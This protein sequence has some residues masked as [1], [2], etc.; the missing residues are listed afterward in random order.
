MV[1]IPSYTHERAGLLRETPDVPAAPGGTTVPAF[2]GGAA[3]RL[4]NWPH[5]TRAEAATV[6]RFTDRNGRCCAEPTL[7]MEREVLGVDY[8]STCST[9]RG[10]GRRA[11]RPP[12]APARRHRRQCRL[13][14][15]C[16]L[17]P[18]PGVASSA[19]TC[20]SSGRG[21]PVNG[22]AATVSPPGRRSWSPPGPVVHTDVMC[23]LG[24]KLSVLRA[25]RQLLRPGG[26]LAF[27]TIHAALAKAQGP[28]RR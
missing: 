26:R 12:P 14:G 8:G 1:F 22:P 21:G 18:P 24:P 10:A 4:G 20:P 6:E 9:T 23:C 17:P 16:A 5:A 3:P 28:V 11:G 2:D 13:A 15:A 7:G 27:T 19:P 25:C